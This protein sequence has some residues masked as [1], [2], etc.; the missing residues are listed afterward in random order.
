VSPYTKIFI[1]NAKEAEPHEID[2]A[3]EIVK[4]SALMGEHPAAVDVTTAREEYLAFEAKYGKPVNW[5]KWFDH[6]TGPMTTFSA[7]PRFPCIVVP[8][9][10]IGKATKDIVGTALRK[11]LIHV[12][13]ITPDG[14]VKRVSKV[15][16]LDPENFKHGW[17]VS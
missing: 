13:R 4:A 14:E 10:T 17:V 5:Q 11:G 16:C 3:V 15:T 2:K 6:V 8:S 12:Y 1:A 9:S 7:T